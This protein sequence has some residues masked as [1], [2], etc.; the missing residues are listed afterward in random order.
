MKFFSVLEAFERTRSDKQHL[1]INFGFTKLPVISMTPTGLGEVD[2]V[3][4]VIW[5][6]C[7]TLNLK[8]LWQKAQIG[9]VAAESHWNLADPT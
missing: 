3:S 4:N 7:C 1:I 8:C 9:F 2:H 6:S 5:L